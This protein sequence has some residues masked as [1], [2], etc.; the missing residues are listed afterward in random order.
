MDSIIDIIILAV[1]L[2]VSIGLHEYAHARA[3]FTLGDPT[4]KLQ[5]RLTPNPLAHIDPMGFLLI[6]LIHFGW[7]KPVQINPAYYK[8]PR[9][10]EFLVAIAGPISNIIMAIFGI[11]FLK[12]Y[13]GNLI[14]FADV[15]YSLFTQFWAQFV[16][17]NVALALFNLLPIP[18]LDGWKFVKLF[19]GNAA[20]K[21]EYILA[22]NPLL[23]IVIFVIL[24]QSGLLGFVGE[25]SQIVVNKL[26]RFINLMR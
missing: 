24:G 8:N 9:V 23:M 21:A 7:G 12:L 3:S 26:M 14:S 16:F 20:L 19:V 5:G 18:P 6:F 11:V 15:S 10:D 17:L 4:P 2:A 25:R 1:I 22:S 13:S